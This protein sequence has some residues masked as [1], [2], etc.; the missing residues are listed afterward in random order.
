MSQDLLAHEV[1]QL[2]RNGLSWSRTAW[3][4]SEAVNFAKQ[5]AESV[6]D[7]VPLAEDP[8]TGI[9]FGNLS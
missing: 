2:I 9:F 4:P 6:G 3:P 1:V 8:G 7:E 5:P